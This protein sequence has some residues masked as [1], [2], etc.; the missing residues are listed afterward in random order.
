MHAYVYSSRFSCSLTTTDSFSSIH[1]SFKSRGH[2]NIYL[3]VISCKTQFLQ[4]FIYAYCTR[5]R[6]AYACAL[7]AGQRSA[8]RPISTYTQR[9]S[10]QVRSRCSS[11]LVSLPNLWRLISRRC[12]HNECSLYCLNYLAV[13]RREEKQTITPPYTLRI[14]YVYHRV[15][16]MWVMDL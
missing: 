16:L 14:T 9:Y 8:A 11:N 7:M 6:T 1:S 10:V 12:G 4:P 3:V 5:T 15:I 2:N 13:S